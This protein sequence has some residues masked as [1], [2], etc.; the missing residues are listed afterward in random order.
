MTYICNVDLLPSS[1]MSISRATPLLVPGPNPRAPAIPWRPDDFFAVDDTVRGGSSRSHI[2]LAQNPPLCRGEIVFSGFLDT[3]TLGGAGFASQ[4]SSS[5]LPVTLS[6]HNF[7]GLRLVVRKQARPPLTSPP[8]GGGKDAVR[9]IVFQIKT[10]V[11]QRRPDGRRESV[12][13]WEWN[14]DLPTSNDDP[15]TSTMSTDEL[16]VYDAGWQ[17]FKPFYR[18]KPVDADKAGEFEPEKTVEWGLMAR[19]NFQMQSGPFS[20]QIHSLSAI[21]RSESDVLATCHADKLA[22]SRQPFRHQQAASITQ[23]I[24]SSDDAA[25]AAASSLRQ[26][27]SSSEYYGFALFI[28]ATVLWIV[29]VMWALTPDSILQMIGIVWYPSRDWAFLLPAW[30]LVIVLTIY[31]VFIGINMYNTPD[32]DDIRNVTGEW[33]VKDEHSL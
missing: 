12:I 30:S 6:R 10:E 5:V 33:C 3:T 16:C 28:L 2:T 22:K 13:V 24:P 23:I 4:V 11:P 25:F 8:E 14:F 31:A 27:S 9:S 29:W 1:P 19:S 32:L 7:V 15:N 21:N 18:G 26:R 20:V 17:D